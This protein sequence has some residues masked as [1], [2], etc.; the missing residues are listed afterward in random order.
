LQDETLGGFPRHTALDELA[1]TPGKTIGGLA[2][3]G[4]AVVL[5]GGFG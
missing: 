1:E 4:F 5:E 3:D 2:G